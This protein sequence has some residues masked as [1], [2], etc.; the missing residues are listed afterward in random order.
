MMKKIF[1]F[2]S[3]FL[4]TFP[5]FTQTWTKTANKDNWG[6]IIGYDY[7]Q[8]VTCVG[9]GA[10]GQG[11]WNLQIRYEPDKNAISFVI[12]PIN[13]DDF[14]PFRLIL[15][16]DVTISLRNGDNIKTFYGL[17]QT[18]D[19]GGPM[20]IIST[21]GKLADIIFKKASGSTDKKLIDELRKNNNYLIL[22]EGYD[23][24]W[25]VRANI[26]GNMPN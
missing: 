19:F 25:F 21:T 2:S 8:T 16:T 4:L 10:T 14:S 23:N 1:L 15:P 5:L 7:V 6:D 13:Q 22:I 11:T 24:T 9:R 18:P 20:I 26:K 3:F 12:F 17:G